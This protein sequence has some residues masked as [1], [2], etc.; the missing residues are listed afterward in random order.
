MR[1]FTLCHSKQFLAG[2]AVFL[3]LVFLHPLLMETFDHN[4][5]D[6][7]AFCVHFSGIGFVLPAF[8][9]LLFLVFLGYA[10]VIPSRKL[11]SRFFL[12]SSG[13]AP[14]ALFLI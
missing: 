9:S 14:P 13:R 8:T 10:L 6:T 11:A 1:T 3:I 5:L 7:C 2:W 12:V 4:H